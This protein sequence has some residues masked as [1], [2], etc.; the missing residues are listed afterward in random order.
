M[1]HTFPGGADRNNG[2][3]THPH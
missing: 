1:S 3:Y 2:R